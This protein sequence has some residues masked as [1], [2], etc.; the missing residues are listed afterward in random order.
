M[1][2]YQRTSRLLTNSNSSHCHPQTYT[3]EHFPK[4]HAVSKLLSSR[5]G[6]NSALSQRVYRCPVVSFILFTILKWWPSYLIYFETQTLHEYFTPNSASNQNRANTSLITGSTPITIKNN[7]NTYSKIIINN[8]D[9]LP[10]I[11]FKSQPTPSSHALEQ[12]TS[13]RQSPFHNYVYTTFPGSKSN[14]TIPS[15]SVSTFRLHLTHS[16]C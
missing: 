2:Q 14:T 8:R 7:S 15:T 1:L 10:E 3:G 9:N 16:H 13:S 5:R 4:P 12:S 6:N 11:Y